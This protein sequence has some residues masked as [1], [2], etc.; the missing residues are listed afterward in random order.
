[1]ASFNHPLD[2][3]SSEEIKAAVDIVRK[4]HPKVSFNV[5]SLHEP[6]KA[7]M[8]KWLESRSS[9]TL[10]PRVAD[11]TVIAPGGRVGDGLVDIHDGKITK[12][13]WIEGFQPIVSPSQ[14]KLP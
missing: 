7:T 3:L 13:E 10:P 9:S 4:S 8:L 12:W 11:V 1:M 5:V 14:H 2:P 6:R